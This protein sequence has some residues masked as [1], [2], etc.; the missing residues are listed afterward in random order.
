M[1]ATKRIQRGVLANLGSVVTRILVQFATLPIL[2][3]NWE[4]ERV[5]VWLAVFAVPAYIALVGNGFAGAGG[6]AA[7][8]AAQSDDWSL[9]RVNFKVSWRISGV[10][11]A[12]LAVAFAAVT[13]PLVPALVDGIESVSGAEISQAVIWLSLYI[14]ATSQ[15]A[16]FEIPFRVAAR[17]PDHILLYNLAILTEVGV[18][19][20]IVTQ[21]DSL[22]VLAM[23]LALTR[24]GST[25][26][27]YFAARRIAPQQFAGAVRPMRQILRDLLKPSLTLMLVPLIFGLNLQGYLLV[28]GAAFGAAALAGFA[29][30]RTITR[31]LDLV[32]NLTF[33]MQ[34]YESGYLSDGKQTVQQRM[35]ATMTLLSV[36]V[37]AGFAA[38]LMLLGPWIQEIYTLGQ[39]RFDSTVAAVLVLAASLRALSSS[40]MSILTAE[41]RHSPVVIVYLVSSAL[42]L[43]LAA[44]LATAG[45]PLHVLLMP[46]LLAEASQLMAAFALAL[47]LLAVTPHQ[48]LRLLLSRERATDVAI[49]VRALA[50]RH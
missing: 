11:T 22:A 4:A 32:T 8:A 7:L 12:I 25:I 31:L 6:S 46:L 19:A 9:A 44:I 20:L 17:Y 15:M 50:G 26:I 21:T 47:P 33:A 28:V 48:F 13:A 14:F 18:I 42:G 49:M 43:C 3:A 35:L 38:A 45:A 34:F 2:F 30:T 37:A 36:A 10:A 27:L 1:S 5:G 41:N 24:A 29:A 16:V 40:P 23:A 39:T